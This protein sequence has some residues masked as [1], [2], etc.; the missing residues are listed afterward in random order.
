MDIESI[1]IGEESR[2]Q[3]HTAPFC[4]NGERSELNARKNQRCRGW[5]V[6]D[7]RFCQRHAP[8]M[9]GSYLDLGICFEK[10][11]TLFATSFSNT[12]KRDV[13]DKLG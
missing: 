10:E 13:S 7:E 2:L 5:M 8:A 6:G 9:R 1:I 3:A 12:E 4:Q 11:Q